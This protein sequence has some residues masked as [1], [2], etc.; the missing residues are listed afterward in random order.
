MTDDNDDDFAPWQLDIERT[1]HPVDGPDKQATLERLSRGREGATIPPGKPSDAKLAEAVNSEY[2]AVE[3]V[4]KVLTAALKAKKAKVAVELSSDARHDLR[5]LENQ[6][7]KEFQAAQDNGLDCAAG[8]FAPAAALLFDRIQYLAWMDVV[9]MADALG[10][11]PQTAT[12]AFA[13]ADDYRG[14]GAYEAMT[15]EIALPNVR[16]ELVRLSAILR[17]EDDSEE[18][19]PEESRDDE[20]EED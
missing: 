5:E 1:P 12:R 20:I 8:F 9:A 3:A 11:Y 18:D 6:N 7:S 15:E 13:L 4:T 2:G 10:C 14:D 17:E 16:Q 19:E